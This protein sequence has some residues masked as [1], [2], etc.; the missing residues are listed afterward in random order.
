MSL[1]VNIKVPGDLEDKVRRSAKDLDLEV[2]Q[3]FAIEL[4]RR[5]TLSHAELARML[6]LDRFETGAFLKQHGI[7]EGSVQMSDLDD[8]A[9]TLKRIMG[10]AG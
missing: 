9:Q 4:F 6:G 7:F 2:T 3:A 5:G 1:N 8:D 10:K